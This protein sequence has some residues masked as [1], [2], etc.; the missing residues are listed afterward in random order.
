MKT[1]RLA[2]I[3]VSAFAAISFALTGCSSSGNGSTSTSGSP[4]S[5]VDAQAALTKAAGQ[6]ATTGYN[7]TTNV[8]NG[9]LTGTATIDPG[10]GASIEQKGTVQGVNLTINVILLGTDFYAKLDAGPLGG[11]IGVDPNTWYKVDTTKVDVSKLPI[12]P[13]SPDALGIA[14]LAQGIKDVKATDA[15]HITGTID[16]SAVKSSLLS[17]GDVASAAANTSAAPFEATLDDQG[18]FSELKIGAGTSSAIEIQFSDYGSPNPISAPAGAKDAP[19]SL[20]SIL[21][22]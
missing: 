1:P 21:G 12:N 8:G 7:L 4:A 15:H 14:G 18:R 19:Q 22:S 10:K 9:T 17:A 20:Y 3:G 13:Q 2:I 16:L 6:L 11:S 5:S